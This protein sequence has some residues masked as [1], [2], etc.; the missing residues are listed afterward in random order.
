MAAP[1]VLT[2]TVNPAL[3]VAVTVEYLVPDHKLRAIDH[4][5]EPG[6]GGINVSRVL[7]R[8]GV[9]S[10]AWI[11]AG[12]ATGD[13]LAALVEAE[14]ITTSVHRIEG[15]TRESIAITDDKRGEQYRIVLPG[16]TVDDPRALVAEVSE[17]AAAADVVVLSGSL[18][19]G[20]P[21]DLYASMCEALGDEVATVVDTKGEALAA[22]VA[23][24]AAVVK[25]SRRELAGLVDWVPAT[26]DEIV[27]AA[28]RV[29][30]RGRVGA[31]AVSLGQD[32]AVLVERSG[33]VTFF[34]PLDV[35]V[36]STVGAGDSMVAGIVAGL[37]RGDALVDAVRLGMAAGTAA[38]LTP[39]TELCRQEDVERL[40]PQ[41][42]TR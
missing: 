3:D 7:H 16:P 27:L 13:E 22:V 8:L 39:G 28:R 6:G 40:L 42:Q 9:D 38:V 4:R 15:V 23:G 10:R 17:L 32:G 25:P 41:V 34:D 29:L 11:A 2:V 21:D 30:D 14:G 19:P 5:R 31:L 35:E 36:R 18:P 33:D 20:V 37:S 26:E 1:N 12:G 24:R